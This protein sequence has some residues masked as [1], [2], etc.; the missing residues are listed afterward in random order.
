M[1]ALAHREVAAMAAV[2]GSGAGWV[3]LA[4]GFLVLTAGRSGEVGGA[5]AREVDYLGGRASRGGGG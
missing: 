4:F 1:P 2:T 5:R 3:K